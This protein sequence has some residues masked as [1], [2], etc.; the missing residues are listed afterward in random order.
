MHDYGSN[1]VRSRSIVLLRKLPRER[2]R[3]D[4]SLNKPSRHTRIK[5]SDA[6]LSYYNMNNRV[7]ETTVLRKTSGDE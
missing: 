1:V 5:D 3:I 7:I 6:R 4:K 2:V